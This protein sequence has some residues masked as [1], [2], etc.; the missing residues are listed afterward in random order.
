MEEKKKCPKCGKDMVVGHP[1]AGFPIEELIK[2]YI[3]TGCRY[4]ELYQKE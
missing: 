4:V 1:F 2:A 3:C